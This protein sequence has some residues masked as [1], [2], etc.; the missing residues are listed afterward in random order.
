MRQCD[1]G[2]QQALQALRD[3]DPDSY[4]QHKQ[5]KITVHETEIDALSTLTGAWHDAQLQYGRREA[6]MIA[7]DNLTRERLNRAARAK[8]K[9]DQLLGEHD[10]IIGGRGWA[11]GDRVITRRNDRRHDVDNGTL[12]TVIAIDAETGSMLLETDSGEPRALDHE[13]VARY[14][15][16]AYALTAHGAQGATVQWAGVTG[17]PDEFTREW[18]YTALSRARETTRIH[19]VSQRSE[20]DR[21]RD[22]YAP[23]HPDPTPNETRDR[24]RQSLTRFET[25]LLAIEHRTPLPHEHEHEHAPEP[26]PSSPS[27]A[28]VPEPDGLGLLRRGR[29]DRS[30][31]TLRL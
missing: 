18:A 2:E 10:V 22:E 17:R 21:E 16:H 25:E 7:R 6:V 9:H 19:L 11:P 28:R 14:L 24:L 3:G 30:G 15:Q 26:E 12:G 1:P 31:R 20:R 29:L 13:Y 4:L 8:L 23:A 5:D 27:R